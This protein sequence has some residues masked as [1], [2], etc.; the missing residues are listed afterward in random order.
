MKRMVLSTMLIVLGSWIVS[1]QTGK[2]DQR[3]VYGAEK[4]RGFSLY[5]PQTYRSGD[6]LP[7]VVSFHPYSSFRWNGQSWRDSLISFAE[8]NGV[9]LLCPDGG[10]N[11]RTDDPEDFDFT[12]N[13]ISRL[14][15][16][17][18]IDPYRIYTLGYSWGAKAA[19]KFSTEHANLIRGMLLMGVSSDQA[20]SEFGHQ[21]ADLRN[22]RCYMVHGSLDAPRVRFH[23]LRNALMSA[24]VCLNV[25]L[26]ENVGHSFNFQERDRV[27]EEAFQWLEEGQCYS[28]PPHTPAVQRQQAKYSNLTVYPNPGYAGSHVWVKGVQAEDVRQIKILYDNGI[29]RRIIRDFHPELP[30][31]GLDRGRYFFI[32]YMADGTIIQRQQQIN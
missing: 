9:I 32:F 5:F 24:G 25:R 19:L 10:A 8:A 16:D 15:Y 26:L 4:D 6:R 30:I 14:L 13:L 2:Y 3:V 23:P 28:L 7:L 12:I 18:R 27:L 31:S 22:M 21:I 29:L 1:A 11:G 20:I 17:Q